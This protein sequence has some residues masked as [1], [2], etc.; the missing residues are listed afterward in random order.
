MEVVQPVDAPLVAALLFENGDVAERS[1]RRAPCLREL[2]SLGQLFFDEL[3]EMEGQLA[4][5]L[6]IQRAPPKQRSEPLLP[7]SSEMRDRHDDP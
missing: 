4:S 2:L 5:E 1:M 7:D 6:G 3:F